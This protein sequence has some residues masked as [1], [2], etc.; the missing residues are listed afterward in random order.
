MNVIRFSFLP[1]LLNN[2]SPRLGHT[3]LC[4]G[5]PVIHL[6][7]GIYYI[8]IPTLR[9]THLGVHRIKA[10][11]LELFR[12]INI[13]ANK[14]FTDLWIREGLR[15]TCLMYCVSGWVQM[16]VLRGSGF[17]P[18]DLGFTKWVGVSHLLCILCLCSIELC[19]VLT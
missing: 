13:S 1:M 14:S 12:V 10:F 19:T 17:R 8:F 7:F 18:M 4:F 9:M 11:V 3:L 16:L 15:F 5:V 6:R 2:Y